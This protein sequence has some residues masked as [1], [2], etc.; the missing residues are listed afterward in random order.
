MKV[1]LALALVVLAK[2]SPIAG[3]LIPAWDY[4]ASPV[5][6]QVAD[7]VT[8]QAHKGQIRDIDAAVQDL[9]SKIHGVG[10]RW[11]GPLMHHA[12][13]A[14]SARAV[15]EL[16]KDVMHE[17]Y[18]WAG[19]GTHDSIAHELHK[20][21]QAVVAARLAVHEMHKSSGIFGVHLSKFDADYFHSKLQSLIHDFDREEVEH[22]IHHHHHWVRHLHHLQQFIHDQIQQIES[23]TFGM[24]VHP[25]LTAQ[26]REVLGCL[27]TLEHHLMELEM[28][29]QLAILE[30]G[31]VQVHHT[32]HDTDVVHG[33][34]VM[35][36]Q[37]F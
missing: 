20:V 1:V 26:V 10:S 33:G 27:K 16:A 34:I 30:L 5:T 15:H 17:N 3:G 8:H 18:R 7:V 19:A 6:H 2:A 32:A 37:A 11:T 29:H 13:E 4:L 22:E 31:K 12:D 25:T 21:V 9:R 24:A 28:A 36:D 35:H 14:V 23:E